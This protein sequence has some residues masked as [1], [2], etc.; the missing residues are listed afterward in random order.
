MG[1][2]MP[3]D[4]LAGDTSWLGPLLQ[5]YMKRRIAEAAQMTQGPFHAQGAIDQAAG[6]GMGAMGTVINP[7]SRY[8][9]WLAAEDPRFAGA[10]QKMKGGLEYAENVSKKGVERMKG[11][12]GVTTQLDPSG[13]DQV[14]SMA[15]D[16]PDHF[17]PG[18]IQNPATLGELKSL[19]ARTKID[20]AATMQHINPAGANATD[21]P[22]TL[23]HEGLHSIYANKPGSGQV[24]QMADD[25]ARDLMARA[26]NRAGLSH[27][28]A[29]PILH[30]YWMDPQHGLVE[31]IAQFL[32]AK[33]LGFPSSL[34]SLNP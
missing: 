27:E 11:A 22:V 16:L 8:F 19:A 5:A 14:M 6:G 18:P 3:G 28:Q 25:R 24:P 13:V 7:E 30:H 20:P 31:A 17:L 2:P 34:Q 9:Q 23:Y 32:N 26:L 4:P 15:A 33:R 10:L 21:T 29:V 12:H 1:D